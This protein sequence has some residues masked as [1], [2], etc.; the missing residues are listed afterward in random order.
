M[1]TDSLLEKCR[2]NKKISHIVF[3]SLPLVF[4]TLF[5][6]PTPQGIRESVCIYINLLDKCGKCQLFKKHKS[7]ILEITPKSITLKYRYL[8][9]QPL[10]VETSL[11]TSQ[12]QEHTMKYLNKSKGTDGALFGNKTLSNSQLEFASNE[13]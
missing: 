8:P 12:H 6:L 1:I 3:S 4:L 2:K 9:N 11:T 13:M 7:L 5:F 10:S